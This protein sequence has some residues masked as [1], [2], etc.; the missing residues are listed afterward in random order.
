MRLNLSVGVLFALSCG[1]ASAAESDPR[2][3]AERAAAAQANA[4]ARACFD[5]A[6]GR[7]LACT[8]AATS[9]AARQACHKSQEE[10]LRVN[11]SAGNG[12]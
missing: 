5:R 12:R 6:E 3:N 9:D 4:V 11:C 2:A 10:D 7:R 8:S 1:L